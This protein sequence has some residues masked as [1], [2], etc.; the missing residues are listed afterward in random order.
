MPTA[1]S[2][3]WWRRLASPLISRWRRSPAVEADD[4]ALVFS[5]SPSRIPSWRQLG[6]LP[7]LLSRRERRFIR[8]CLSL[9]VISLLVLLGQAVTRHVVRVPDDGGSL[10]EGMV[11]TPQ[12]LNPVLARPFTADTELSRLL[13]RG[14]LRVDERSQI[15]PD[16]AQS[17]TVSSDGKTYTAVLR[18]NL[19]WSDGQPLTAD[20]VRYTFETI[21]DSGYQSPNQGLFANLTVASPDSRT[22]VFTIPEANEPFRSVLTLGLLPAKLWQDQTP[23]TFPLAELNVKPVG[24]GPFKFQSVTKDRNG[25]VKAFTFVQNKLFA[26]PRPRLDKINVKFYPDANSALDALKS[27]AVDSFGGLDAANSDQ[28][29]KY[30]TVTPFAL[31]QLT[32]VFFSQK[33]NPALKVKEVRQALAMA[34][35]RPAL[36][37][38]AF[39]GVGRPADGPLL[40]GQPAYRDDIKRFGFSVDQA[41]AL[42]DQAGWKRGDNGLRQKGGAALKFALTTVDDPTYVVASQ[43]LAQAWRVIGADVEVKTVA[44]DRIQKDIIRPRQYDALLFGQISNPDGDPYSLWHSSQQRD[45]GFALAVAFIKK[46]DQALAAA[47]TATD[48]KTHDDALRDF[49]AI[50][51]DE[52][53]AI[54]LVQ[55]EYLYAHQPSLRGLVGDRFIAPADRFDNISSWYVKTR[56][57]WK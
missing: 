2:S 13:F 4:R 32:G 52:V 55:S 35:D 17:V 53:P 26:G 22:V 11:G 8:L 38:Q 1:N 46:V 29:K 6:Y 21:A 28:V 7:K 43:A 31:S 34:V 23:Q 56:L 16:L 12:Y 33:T 42:L 24:N 40:P 37:R 41:N 3:S 19:K 39:H 15:V 20:D 44:P 45:A 10:T 5:L 14:L 54:I 18:P 9:A 50:I 48:A 27:N 49:Q 36:I 30:R 57:S 25:N 47:R 51:A